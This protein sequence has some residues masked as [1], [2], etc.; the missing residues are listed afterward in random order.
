MRGILILVFATACVPVIASESNTPIPPEKVIPPATVFGTGNSF[1]TT[2]MDGFSI[3]FVNGQRF[4]Y[5]ELPYTASLQLKEPPIHVAIFYW[6][7]SEAA[8]KSFRQGRE[9]VEKKRAGTVSIDKISQSAG[10]TYFQYSILGRISGCSMVVGNVHF[11][12]TDNLGA[13]SK[14]KVLAQATAYARFLSPTSTAEPS[15]S[16]QP[17][18]PKTRKWTNSEGI[19][20][21]AELKA[22]HADSNT[23]DLL[24]SDGKLF[25][26]LS[27]RIF[28]NADQDYVKDFHSSM[29]QK[30]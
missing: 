15:S 10:R 19:T 6:D 20:I 9:N 1:D 17:V 12:V 8:S 21:E 22:F 24:R 30:H 11:V 28:S 2:L 16:T 29:G 14:E 5:D 4:H 25:K 3:G 13:L 23:I 18:G 26:G 27:L 7:S